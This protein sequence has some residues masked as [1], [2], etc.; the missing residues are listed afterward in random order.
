MSDDSYKLIKSTGLTDFQ[1]SSRVIYDMNNTSIVS[2]HLLCEFPQSKQTRKQLLCVIFVKNS[3]VPFL[4]KSSQYE[5]YC[6]LSLEICY[7]IV[8]RIGNTRD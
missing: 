1:Y 5:C 2:I 6:H 3:L 8:S 4:L 7:L